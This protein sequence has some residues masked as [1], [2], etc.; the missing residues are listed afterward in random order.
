MFRANTDH[1]EAL[2]KH[3]YTPRKKFMSKNDVMKL[4]TKDSDILM[5]EKEVMFCI[6]MSKMTVVQETKTPKQYEIMQ[7]SEFCEC[8]ARLADNRYKSQTSIP[9]Q[10]KIEFLLDDL[11]L[12]IGVKRRDV[13]AEQEEMSESDDAY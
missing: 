5:G 4:L 11:F 8:I 6:G 1:V 9:L 12:V 3:Y 7:F 10:T 2:M 13:S